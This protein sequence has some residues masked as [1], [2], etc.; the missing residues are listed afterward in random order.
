[1]AFSATRRNRRIGRAIAAALV[2]GVPVMGIGIAR[3]APPDNSQ[4]G[5]KVHFV[6]ARVKPIIKIGQLEFRDLNANGQLDVYEDWRKPVDQRVTDLLSRMS[7]TAIQAR[8]V[9]L[10]TRFFAA[11]TFVG[12][13]KE[14]GIDFWLA[15]P[16]TLA[17]MR[18]RRSVTRWSTGLRQSS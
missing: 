13:Q 7:R 6:E 16:L 4:A 8:P 17:A 5:G 12:L 18:E 1:M 3:A 2:C 11:I 15:L 10:R 9:A 14:Y